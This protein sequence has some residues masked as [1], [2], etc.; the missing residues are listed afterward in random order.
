MYFVERR[1]EFKEANTLAC[2]QCVKKGCPL[3]HKKARRE[4]G[5][6]CVGSPLIG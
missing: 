4:A 5:F 6:V 1:K 3:L 2:F